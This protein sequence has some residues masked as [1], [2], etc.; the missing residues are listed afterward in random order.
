MRAASRSWPAFTASAARAS[1][2]T[3]RLAPR[4]ASWRSSSVASVERN[5]RRPRP[6]RALRVRRRLGRRGSR[7][8]A[9]APHLA[10]RRTRR[11]R[12]ARPR[13]RRAGGSAGSGTGCRCAS[14]CVRRCCGMFAC[15]RS[16]AGRPDRRR[17]EHRRR[18]R[19]PVPLSRP[20][21][22]SSVSGAGR[23]RLVP[24]DARDRRSRGHPGRPPERPAPDR[25][26]GRPRAALRPRTGT[27]H[28]TT[29]PCAR[30]HSRERA[31]GGRAPALR[32]PPN[33]SGRPRRIAPLPDERRDGRVRSSRHCPTAPPDDRAPH[34]PRYRRARDDRSRSRPGLR[35]T[36][37]PVPRMSG[38]PP[39]GRRRA[40]LGPRA[41]SGRPVAACRSVRPRIRPGLSRASSRR[42]L[43]GGSSTTGP[44]V[45]RASRYRARERD[46]AR[47]DGGRHLRKNRRRPTL[48]GGLPPSTIGAGG[49]NCRVRNGNGCVPAAMATGSSVS[50]GCLRVLH[51]EHERSLLHVVCAIKPSAD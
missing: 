51:S 29:S 43:R 35:A 14:G 1:S 6:R 12:P 47:L 46:D 32:P 10:Q 9:A 4:P 15:S 30:H 41:R 8:L 28:R 25:A 39:G 17:S 24:R 42:G 20:A 50:L 33:G 34:S 44:V 48:P 31:P 11:S 38:R 49:L 13:A 37:T 3:A 19:S 36:S 23:A 7:P 26:S 5:G 22:S 27:S 21:A 16:R 18:P 45:G 40:R 2:C